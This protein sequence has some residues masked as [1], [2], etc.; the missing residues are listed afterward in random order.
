MALSDE[1]KARV[2]LRAIVEQTV[3]WDA[4]KSQPAKGDYWAP[5]PFHGERSPSFHVT[6]PKG[7]GGQFY[8]FGCQAKGS[9]IDFLMQR[10]GLSFT[11]AVRALADSENIDRTADPA[12]IAAFKAK[13]EARQRQAERA[14]AELADRGVTKAH[15]V[16]RA[17]V[18]NHPDLMA[19][20]EGRG[21]RIE[22][23]GGLPA[24]LRYHADLPCYDGADENGRAKLIHRGPAMVAFIGRQKLIGVH[25]TWF[26][27]A[28]PRKG[29]AHTPDGHKVPKKMLG[30]TGEIF[31]NPVVLSKPYCPRV[32]VGEGI[33][34][35]LA[36]YSATR[37]L[38]PEFNA[39]IEAALSLGALAGPEAKTGA[40]RGVGRTGKRLPNPSPELDGPRPGWLPPDGVSCATILADPST[41]C[42]DAARIHAERALAKISHACPDGARLAIPLGHWDH[43]QDFADLAKAGTLYEA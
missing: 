30:R 37:A 28:D 12:R 42:P 3:E 14:A 27:A 18:A 43:D 13:S 21:I 33:E 7:T 19:Y 11:A 32:V 26:N 16:W 6:E 23:I 34:T 20:L 24:T 39:R 10:D 29:R 15:N 35:T 9:V 38:N 31:G 40:R 36:V 22:A 8:C 2:S 25:R 5:C 4:R 17:S 41:K 1:I